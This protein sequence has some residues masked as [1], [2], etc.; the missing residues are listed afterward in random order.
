M[1]D[2]QSDFQP[3]FPLTLVQTAFRSYSQN[4]F[5]LS[6]FP[7]ANSVDTANQ[8]WSIATETNLIAFF[9]LNPFS[10]NSEPYNAAFTTGRVEKLKSAEATV[11]EKSSPTAEDRKE[12][13]VEEQSAEEKLVGEALIPEEALA[14]RKT[15]EAQFSKEKL[16]DV[17]DKSVAERAV[18]I[19][20][21]TASGKP[22]ERATVAEELLGKQAVP[23]ISENKVAGKAVKESSVRKKQP[24]E[25]RKRKREKPER[26][27]RKSPKGA[28]SLLIQ[29]DS[30][31]AS[32]AGGLGNE[33]D[34]TSSNRSSPLSP[35]STGALDSP[36]PHCS[37]ET[38]PS[39]PGH[40]Q[41]TSQLTNGM[42]S[43]G[44]CQ[45]P[46][47]I[48]PKGSARKRCL[49]SASPGEMKKS[50]VCLSNLA[51]PSSV[52][53]TKPKPFVNL[54]DTLSSM[55]R[56]KPH[57]PGVVPVAASTVANYNQG[58]IQSTFAANVTYPTHF[59]TPGHVTPS[60]LPYPTTNLGYG[61][62]PGHFGPNIPPAYYQTAGQG[63]AP[64]PTGYYPWP[65]NYPPI[66]GRYPCSY[67]GSSTGSGNVYR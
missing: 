55:Q 60:G 44:Y 22:S 49:A 41:R 32:S 15:P 56:L 48:S 40:H 2:G 65:G 33:S 43:P 14:G 51:V 59:A 50:K 1:F 54:N 21:G 64:P 9:S 20:D 61:P 30:D 16:S 57:S 3:R 63:F 34:D 8:L 6:E 4:V 17:S 45:R 12:N 58:N 31:S 47:S 35:M 18:T 27:N 66:H 23:K 42:I 7:I 67:S 13:E 37:T 5:A 19:G 52:P 10:I 26:K 39:P 53:D 28:L 24:K 62:N 25:P 11:L 29:Y 46:K 36:H 38:S